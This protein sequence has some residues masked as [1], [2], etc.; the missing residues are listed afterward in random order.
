MTEKINEICLDKL[1]SIVQ[2]PFG[3]A[4]MY[5]EACVWC[6]DQNKHQNGVLLKFSFNSQAFSYPISWPEERIDLDKIRNHYNSDDALPFGAEAIAFFV[7][8][9]HT[10]YKSL[11]RAVKKTGIDY[12]LSNESSTQSLPFQNAGRLE[13]SGILKQSETN[14]ITKR[15]KEKIIQT[16][17]SE[18]TTLPVY[19][20]VVAFDDPCAKMEFKD[21]TSK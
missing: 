5:M 18:K 20:V 13:I 7:S 12:W 1:E 21:V 17:Q 2:I 14:T 10:E 9:N 8:I 3:K 19:V 16:N 15:V 11:K 4:A 6:L